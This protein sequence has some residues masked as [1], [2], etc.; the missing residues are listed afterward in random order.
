M[1][2][3]IRIDGFRVNLSLF[4]SEYGPETIDC[5]WMRINYACVVHRIAS[6]WVPIGRSLWHK[7]MHDIITYRITH[8]RIRGY[9]AAG[10]Q[11]AVLKGNEWI[12]SGYVAGTSF[13]LRRVMA[14]KLTYINTLV[15]SSF[16]H[17]LKHRCTLS[18]L[19]WNWCHSYSKRDK[20]AFPAI[21]VILRSFKIDDIRVK[22]V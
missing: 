22:K 10:I 8:A 17:R 20:H 4:F 18:K 16:T 9:D 5:K 1:E 15:T 14:L 21:S 2:F 3:V 11:Y 19:V 7:I 6:V 12:L 13:L